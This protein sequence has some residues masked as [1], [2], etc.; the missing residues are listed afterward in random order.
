MKKR[1]V[2]IITIICLIIGFCACEGSEGPQGEAGPKAIINDFNLTF[3]AG[4]SYKI[5]TI[6][7]DANDILLIY[8]V[9]NS[10]TD[11]S[12]YLLPYLLYNGNGYML[13]YEYLDGGVTTIWLKDANTGKPG[14]IQATT[15]LS[16][17]A[18]IIEGAKQ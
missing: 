18:V 7:K 1:I 11:A 4:D 2:S 16:F 15:T 14:A 8:W 3:N 10:D 12:Y 5:T 17:R 13:D 6:S 9:D